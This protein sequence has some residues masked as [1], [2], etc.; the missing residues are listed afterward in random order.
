MLLK[1][2]ASRQKWSTG[3]RSNGESASMLFQ[4]GAIRN[5]SFQPN[6]CIDAT[7]LCWILSQ[8]PQRESIRLLP[9]GVLIV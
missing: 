1:A 3:P 5:G 6:G 9:S 2:M 7:Q 8:V 4:L